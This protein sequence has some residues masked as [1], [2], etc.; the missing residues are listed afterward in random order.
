MLADMGAEVIKIET[1]DTGD[2]GRYLTTGWFEGIDSNG[3]SLNYYWENNNRNKKSL[4]IDLKTE[5]GL[6]VLYRLIEKSDAFVTNFRE[7]SL[8][9]LGLGY[10]KV[11]EINPKLVYSLGWGFGAKGPDATRPAADMAAQARGG[12]MSQSFSPAPRF[13]WGGLADQTGAFMLCLGT[14]MGLLT[15]ERTGIGQKVEE[16]LFGTQLAVGALMAQ[17]TLFSGKVPAE[18][19]R[20]ALSPFW[21]VYK[22]KDNKW[23]AVSVLELDRYWPLLCQVLELEWLLEDPRFKKGEDRVTTYRDEL[24][25][26]LDDAIIKKTR[27]EWTEILNKTE[28]IWA[29]VQDYID[30]L[31]DPQAIENEYVV[32]YDHPNA[33]KVKVLGLPLKFSETPGKI[34]HLAPELGQHTEEVLTETLGYSWDEVESLKGKQVI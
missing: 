21:N 28:I 1:R 2:P 4:A 32:E 22:C 13:V 18:Y 15:R 8:I 19:T 26:L 10:E 23:L 34:R 14:T 25:D 17:G 12:I 9:R 20:K 29:P 31:T 7:K 16:S 11:H 33:G 3:V 24:I 5:E 6:E 27:D 30:A